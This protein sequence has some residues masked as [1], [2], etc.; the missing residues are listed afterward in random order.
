MKSIVGRSC[1]EERVDVWIWTPV[2]N[3]WIAVVL[4]AWE[5]FCLDVVEHINASFQMVVRNRW[6]G[7]WCRVRTR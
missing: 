7:D 4:A 1:V 6:E 3:S 5:L 2:T